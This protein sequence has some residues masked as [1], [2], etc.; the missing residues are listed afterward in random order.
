MEY[1]NISGYKFTELNNLHSIQAD[2]RALCDGL[3]LK[4]T[5]LLGHE[6]INAFASGTRQQIDQFMAALIRLFPVWNL[7]KAFLSNVP[8][9]ICESK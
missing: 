6:G 9:N 4:G 2:L 1:I 3:D 5:L 8:L 7:K